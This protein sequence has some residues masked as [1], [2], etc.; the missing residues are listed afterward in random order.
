MNT[1]QTIKNRLFQVIKLTLT[2]PLWRS[3]FLF[4]QFPPEND[5]IP[6]INFWFNLKNIYFLN[7]SYSQKKLYFTLLKIESI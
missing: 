1:T 5:Q 6:N 7:F 3:K 4:H 2:T